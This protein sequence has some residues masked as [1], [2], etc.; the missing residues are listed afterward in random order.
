M[1]LLFCSQYV[2]EEWL[3]KDFNFSKALYE[4]DSGLKCNL[5]SFVYSIL[6]KE[7]KITIVHPRDIDTI[8]LN[9]FER[10]IYSPIFEFNCPF[11]KTYHLKTLIKLNEVKEKVRTLLPDPNTFKSLQRS[12]T[13]DV[14]I[15]KKDYWKIINTSFTEDERL[16][17]KE[18]VVY[19][20]N[21]SKKLADIF[22]NHSNEEILDAFTPVGNTIYLVNFSHLYDH[23]CEKV[24]FSDKK[25]KIGFAS[26]NFNRKPNKTYLKAFGITE[27][28][29][30]RIGPEK[31]MDV[32]YKR[33]LSE[34]E[35]EDAYNTYKFICCPFTGGKRLSWI[36]SRILYAI[37]NGSI[38]LLV[39][40][41]V[42]YFG[43]PFILT[44]PI[45]EYTDEE[46]IEIHEKQKEYFYSHLLSPEDSFKNILNWLS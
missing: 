42:K 32:K 33:G 19:I 30:E 11:I 25:S 1:E 16:I 28:D 15:Y 2:N 4:K 41:D 21:N 22:Y 13:F 9:N 5:E 38:P 27:A 37:K 45:F 3:N 44:K 14:N 17:A 31:R 43:K 10:I 46:L 34:V 6:S 26:I 24:K 29:I 23:T 18:F 35:L 39:N 40:H 7:N 36:R 8:N 20:W 12:A